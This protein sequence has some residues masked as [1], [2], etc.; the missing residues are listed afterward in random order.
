MQAGPADLVLFDQR[1]AL[2]ELGRTQRAGVPA[3]AAAEHDDVIPADT[4]PISGPISRPISG[5]HRHAS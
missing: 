4:V 5:C 2:A 3:T 1:H